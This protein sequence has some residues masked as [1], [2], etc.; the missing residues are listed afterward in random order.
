MSEEKTEKVQKETPFSFD[1]PV[2][3][4][5]P[6]QGVDYA[7]PAAEVVNPLST[8]MA[9]PGLD[10]HKHRITPIPISTAVPENPESMVES[11]DQ[12]VRETSDLI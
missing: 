7:G 4:P 5:S 8:T 2:S 11:P 3:R 10:G 12:I 1:V 9:Y 6:N